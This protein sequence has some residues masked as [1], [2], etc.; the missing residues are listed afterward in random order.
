MPTICIEF[1]VFSKGDDK[2]SQF[3]DLGG[4]LLG[5]TQ[6]LSLGLQICG[7]TSL[8]IIPATLESKQVTVN[9]EIP[10]D[11][12]KDDND[13]VEIYDTCALMII[14]IDRTVS[15]NLCSS[16]H[17]NGTGMCTIK[18]LVESTKTGKLV[19]IYYGA[20]KVSQR[21]VLISNVKIVNGGVDITDVITIVDN[22]MKNLEVEAFKTFCLTT[23]KYLQR[24]G[25]E[26]GGSFT[27][28]SDPLGLAVPCFNTVC[29]LNSNDKNAMPLSAVLQDRVQQTVYTL[30][31]LEIVAKYAETICFSGRS[32]E[33]D[34]Y[35]QKTENIIFSQFYIEEDTSPVVDVATQMSIMVCLLLTYKTDCI[36]TIANGSVNK[37]DVENWMFGSAGITRSGDC[38][39]G[40]HFATGAAKQIEM[41]QYYVFYDNPEKDPLKEFV[42]LK[43]WRTATVFHTIGISLLVATTGSAS[44]M[45]GNLEKKTKNRVGHACVL[46]IPTIGFAR[47]C[48]TGDDKEGLFPGDDKEGLLPGDDKESLLPGD[49]KQALLDVPVPLHARLKILLDQ[50]IKANTSW[51]T[52]D[53]NA[54]DKEKFLAFVKDGTVPKMPTDEIWSEKDL[55][56]GGTFLHMEAVA[57]EGTC[58][59]IG[60]LYPP[61]TNKMWEEYYVETSA[62][63]ISGGFKCNSFQRLSNLAVSEIQPKSEWLESDLDSFYCEF[64]EL[65]VGGPILEVDDG[66]YGQYILSKNSEN[67][68]AA[69]SRTKAIQ[70]M[71]SQKQCRFKCG[72]S[73]LDIYEN[74]TERYFAVPAA[75]L[76][77]E[78]KEH[79]KQGCEAAAKYAIVNTP[80]ASASDL[81][82]GLG[83]AKELQSVSLNENLES[84]PAS[85]KILMENLSD[86][87]FGVK[88][89]EGIIQL[90]KEWLCKIQEMDTS[91]QNHLVNAK[92][93]AIKQFISDAKD[94][95][96]LKVE[97]AFRVNDADSIKEMMPY[98]L[99]EQFGVQEIDG[100]LEKAQQSLGNANAE[101]PL[102]TT[103]KEFISRAEDVLKLKA[104]QALVTAAIKEADSHPSKKVTNTA[105][106]LAHYI[107]PLDS[108][109]NSPNMLAASISSASDYAKA[110]NLFIRFTVE[111]SSLGKLIYFSI[112]KEG[113]KLPGIAPPQ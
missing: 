16:T 64:I 73:P 77:S 69:K 72:V 8:K 68:E 25:L 111:D 36:S 19:E 100:F 87:A 63:D 93:T 43:R 2:K 109:S 7:G 11:N 84:L 95:L 56:S 5:V 80:Q 50:V 44:T 41:A 97:Y 83:A 62:R 85:I 33:K 96:K 22:P 65:I 47:A 17:K 1:D 81:K 27:C 82:R 90:A 91:K 26:A 6:S 42:T 105:V 86:E 104:A 110:N 24:R 57:V 70:Q 14:N 75:R 113:N 76:T 31:E 40:A 35:I 45:D 21:T 59:R 38:D 53:E 30:S 18:D 3:A 94:K 51:V 103:I 15:L 108:W 23:T 61:S 79:L 98:L 9:L 48:I 92:E 28:I 60:R 66:A 34:Q 74:E 10:N 88:E 13:P 112:S 101:S 29:G 106:H 71:A 78:E 32:T 4:S 52:C 107:A 58:P 39:D 12:F 20:F 67:K 89:I 99:S 102:A 37:T 54:K 55:C 49:D 46:L